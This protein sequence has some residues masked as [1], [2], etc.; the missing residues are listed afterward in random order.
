MNHEVKLSLV[1]GTG[2]ALGVALAVVALWC[3][4]YVGLLAMHSFNVFGTGD[5]E[6]DLFT[7]GRTAFS[8]VVLVITALT[9]FFIVKLRNSRG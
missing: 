3:T 8:V 6:T 5:V 1:R 2:I 4:Y 7:S 9:I